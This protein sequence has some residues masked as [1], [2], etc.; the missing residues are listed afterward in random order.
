MNF[1][2]FMSIR[3]KNLV[4][5]NQ[6]KKSDIFFKMQNILKKER[7]NKRYVSISLFDFDFNFF[8][9]CLVVFVSF[10]FNNRLKGSFLGQFF[11]FKGCFALGTCC[12]LVGLFAY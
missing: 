2:Y 1:E 12:C 7:K 3:T 6:K 8:G 9:N 4:F 11:D 10:E 5:I